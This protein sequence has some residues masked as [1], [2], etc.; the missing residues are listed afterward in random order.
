MKPFYEMTKD[1]IDLQ[2]MLEE[3]PDDEWLIDTLQGIQLNLEQKALNTVALIKNI[4]NPLKDIDDEIKRLTAH[5]NAIENKVKRLKD[6]IRDAMVETG[7]DEIKNSLVKIKLLGTVS[8]N[9]TDI[10]AVPDEFKKVVVETKP[11]KNMIKATLK[12]GNLVAGAELKTTK[13]V[14]FY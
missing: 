2:I 5:K 14:K 12:A 3:N 10:D 11:D 13:F 1:F 8:V 9:V 6:Y 7:T 4:N